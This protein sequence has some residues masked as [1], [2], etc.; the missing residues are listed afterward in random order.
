[1]LEMKYYNYEETTAIRIVNVEGMLE[2]C[3]GTNDPAHKKLMDLTIHHFNAYEEMVNYLNNW[4]KT[5]FVL[6]RN[7]E[8][9][10]TE[11]LAL[12]DILPEPLKVG[13]VVKVIDV[14]LGAKIEIIRH[15]ETALLNSNTLCKILE[16]PKP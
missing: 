3:V 4:E 12:A 5:R 15:D 9:I 1:M 6:H 8:N 16:L 13:D 14:P 11:L 2:P 10:I 7:P